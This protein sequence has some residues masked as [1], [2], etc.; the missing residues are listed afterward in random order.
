MQNLQVQ[1]TLE[2][3]TI[4][5]GTFGNDQVLTLTHELWYSPDLQINLAAIRKDPRTGTED[6]RVNIVSHTD[7]DPAALA[8]PAGYR[9]EDNRP[10]SVPATAFSSPSQTTS[11]AQQAMSPPPSATSEERSDSRCRNPE[12]NG[13]YRIGCGVTAPQVIYKVEPEFSDE[14]RKKKFSGT[15]RV[16][17]IVSVDGKPTNLRVVK[18]AAA[19]RNEKEQKIGLSLDRKAI[20]A[21]SQ[22]KFK[23]ATFQGKPVPVQ[24]NVEV[25][26]QIF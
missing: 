12:P 4:Q 23:P 25:N 17:L 13:D 5:P 19:N 24:V 15:T 7:P 1:G 26:F 6:V 20:E 10:K 14:A 2:T 9:V 8:I 18:S 11:P 16:Q 22:Y 21:V 3:T